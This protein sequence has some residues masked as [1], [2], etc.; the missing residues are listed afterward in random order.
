MTLSW[1]ASMRS[2]LA[3][4]LAHPEWWAIALAGFLVRGGILIVLLPIITLPTAASVTTSLAPPIE[5]LLLGRPSL[6]GV[7]LV[8][9]ALALILVGLAA[10]GIAGSWFDLVL[11][12]EA[13]ADEELE[14]DWSQA[15]GS[16]LPAF[17]ARIGA[18]APT[19]VALA[20]A[21]LRL[22]TATYDELL[23]PGDASLP[24]AARVVLRA[25]DAIV[26]VLVTWLVA[27]AAGGLAA[28]RAGAG[29]PV[30]RSL[31]SAYRGVVGRRGVATLLLTSAVVAAIAVPF[32]LAAGRSWERVRAYLIDEVPP[33]D[34]GA[35]LVLLVGTVVLGL[36]VLG[37]ALAWR[38]TAWTTHL[39][40][41][42][43]R[44]AEPEPGPGSGA[45]SVAAGEGATG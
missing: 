13:A 38:A 19:L 7:V 15:R 35:A 42:R 29:E 14:V 2:A 43:A 31:R 1:G 20:Y 45:A 18:H 44:D 5:A 17:A 36:A 25:P 22:G 41:R 26:V 27:E 23:S 11:T 4:T 9:I 21:G 37:G 39:S 10:L 28:R 30:W 8:T 12:R 3:S 32:V 40:T 34:L 16:T 24:L 6:E 33:I